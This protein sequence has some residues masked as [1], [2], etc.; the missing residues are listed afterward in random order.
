MVI[1]ITTS[2]P[3]TAAFEMSVGVI[4]CSIM[5]VLRV[6]FFRCQ[7]FKP[8]LQIMM[9]PGFIVVNKDAGG[10]VHGIDQD[11]PFEDAAFLNTLFDLR[12]DSQKLPSSVDF[13]PKFFSIGFHAMR[14]FK[15]LNT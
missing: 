14:G 6:R 2:R 8:A 7:L 12:G 9:K 5:L 11:H 13:K 1:A 4:L 15:N 10:D 3:I